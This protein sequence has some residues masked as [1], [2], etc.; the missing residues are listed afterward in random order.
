MKSGDK[1][2]HAYPKVA[3]VVGV[4]YGEKINYMTAA[5]H[6]YL[7]H[8]PP[9]YSVSIS[10]KRHTHNMVVKA[11]EF[12]CNFL[13][14]DML[15]TIHKTGRIS[16]ADYDKTEVLNLKTKSGKTINTPMLSDAYAVI[17]CKLA[18]TVDTGDHTLFVGKITHV[19]ENKEAFK[20]NG[21]LNIDKISPTLYL[22][23]DTYITINKTSIKSLPREIEL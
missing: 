14:F 7:S 8:T 19:E 15:D 13:P 5:W 17:E 12:N 11:K 6:T 1:L 4:K 20:E 3:T 23:S 9:I 18:Q 22:G 16:G 21:L 2:Y 10:P